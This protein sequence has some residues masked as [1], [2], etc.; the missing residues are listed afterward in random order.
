MKSLELMNNRVKIISEDFSQLKNI[1]KHLNLKKNQIEAIPDYM[2]DFKILE[3]SSIDDIFRGNQIKELSPAI[4]KAMKGNLA[5]TM[6]H[7]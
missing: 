5:L 1:D 4:L 7:L 6:N 2:V 3:T